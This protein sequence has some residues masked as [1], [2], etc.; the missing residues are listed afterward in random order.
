MRASAQGLVTQVTS[1][2]GA[3]AG[4]ILSGFVVDRFAEVVRFLEQQKL[5]EAGLLG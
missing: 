4:T 2:V 3:L 5:L 1:G